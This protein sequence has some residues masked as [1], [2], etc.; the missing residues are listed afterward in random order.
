MRE[1]RLPARFRPTWE[2]F[3]AVVT[4]VRT[5]DPALSFACTDHHMLAL[6]AFQ[7]AL[8]LGYKRPALVLDQ[9]IDR[10]VD[11]RFS[12]GVQIAQ[13]ALPVARR[14][15]AFYLLRGARDEP[16]IFRR[17]LELGQPDAL[18]TLYNVV[19]RWI[20]DAGILASRHVGLIQLEWRARRFARL[21]GNES[22]QRR[23]RGGRRRDGDRHDSQQRVRHP[24]F[25]LRNAGWQHL[26]GWDDR[27]KRLIRQKQYRVDIRRLPWGNFRRDKTL[28][29]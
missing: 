13:Q 5:R 9:V 2:E 15:K 21:G 4:G 28:E 18:L 19:R 8:E 17:W 6:R 16:A 29:G 24:R 23:R 11:G 3:P 7:K 12:A 22:A 1:N 25:S 14:A 20:E 26:G 27:E 10:L